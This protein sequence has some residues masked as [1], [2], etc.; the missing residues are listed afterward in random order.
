MYVIVIEV[1]KR[2]GL[3]VDA[4]VENEELVLPL[5]TGKPCISKVL[6]PLSL[7]IS[8]SRTSSVLAPSQLFRLWRFTANEVIVCSASPG[9]P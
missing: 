9:P 6:D 4:Q 5:L 2:P 8:E 1:H 7:E 3:Y